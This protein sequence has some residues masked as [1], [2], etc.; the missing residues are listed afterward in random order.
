MLFCL[1]KLII[2]DSLVPTKFREFWLI[3]PF[4]H[5]YNNSN[6]LPLWVPFAAL[7]PALLVFVVLFFEV[8]LTGCVSTFLFSPTYEPLET[9]YCV[10]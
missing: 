9:M 2:P 1:Q 6:Y 10:I 7:F 3:S 8:E 5:N 4:G